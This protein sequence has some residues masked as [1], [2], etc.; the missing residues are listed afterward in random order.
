ME[1]EDQSPTTAHP[2]ELIF[3]CSI[4]N[5]TLT[6][7]YEA[8]DAQR[9]GSVNPA[10]DIATKLW[11]TE[12]AHITCS[13]H[14]EGGGAPFHRDGEAPVAPCPFCSAHRNDSTGKKLFGV[15]GAR[16]GQYD[17]RIPKVFFQ[18]PPVKLP[19]DDTEMHAL[20]FHYGALIRFGSSALTSLKDLQSSLVSAKSNYAA[21]EIAHLKL[22]TEH[23]KLKSR[24]A[25][26]DQREKEIR[27]WK[28]KE[29]TIKNYL[30]QF[31][32][33]VEQNGM[34][35]AQLLRLGVMPAELTSNS[36]ENCL[37]G[38]FPH[39]KYRQEENLSTA[40]KQGS[41]EETGMSTLT[42]PATSS[43]ATLPAT[44]PVH[45]LKRP[46]S[47]FAHP[48]THQSHKKRRLEDEELDETMR[49]PLSRN[50]RTFSRDMMPPPP[51][52]PQHQPP[53]E[54][55]ASHPKSGYQGHEEN[56]LGETYPPQTARPRPGTMTLAEHLSQSSRPN[57]RLSSFAYATKEQAIV[58]PGAFSGSATLHL[59]HSRHS[60]RPSP[61]DSGYSSG[62]HVRESVSDGLRD[63]LSPST[64]ISVSSR[65]VRSF[66]HHY[67]DSRPLANSGIVT[68]RLQSSQIQRYSKVPQTPS[69]LRPHGLVSISGTPR[70]P[71]SREF[72]NQPRPAPRF[73]PP[74]V[75]P[76]RPSSMQ[77][78]P[79]IPSQLVSSAN[80]LSFISE[81]VLDNHVDQVPD[82]FSFQSTPRSY[83]GSLNIQ[84]TRQIPSRS[85]VTRGNTLPFTRAA[86]L[87]S[88]MP[89]AT[90]T[91]FKSA[92]RMSS[93]SSASNSRR[94]STSARAGG[95]FH[96]AR[97]MPADG[98]FGVSSGRRL[99]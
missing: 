2:L 51:V 12:C 40:I 98:S 36:N 86:P 89:Q 1:G 59:P 79:H 30:T 73:Q 31:P 90:M 32:D 46:V 13:E 95:E 33:I 69:R 71:Q 62:R 49:H 22:R 76:S 81:P 66:N 96:F 42:D 50:S 72:F 47:R 10:Y 28:E 45:L 11:F 21:L 7:V 8:I 82:H 52:P 24:M 25:Y 65:G 77:L 5:K 9:D 26:L 43:S 15:K 99:Y 70:Y 94:Y 93:I 78:P 85:V 3:S 48:I 19:N 14:L 54:I 80:A 68:P 92:G 63:V 44:N 60:S 87:P 41:A 97:R 58:S 83:L 84:E 35:K 67:Q 75:R 64:R 34:L 88:T 53:N 16:D 37:R 29:T 55:R 56:A 17:K 91:P 39:T 23:G 27:S 74:L 6:E 18:L 57:S 4:C 20:N 61:A 38:Q